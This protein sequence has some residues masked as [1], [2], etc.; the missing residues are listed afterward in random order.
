MEGSYKRI[1]CKGLTWLGLDSQLASTAIS[2]YPKAY[3]FT[4]L[5][6]SLCGMFIVSVV[7]S[8]FD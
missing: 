1:Y 7:T 6:A 5:Q 8:S 4:S 3:Y 2:K